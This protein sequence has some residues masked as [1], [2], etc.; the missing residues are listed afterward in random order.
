MFTML[1]WSGSP[2]GRSTQGRALPAPGHCLKPL[3]RWTNEWQPLN[4]RDFLGSGGPEWSQRFALRCRAGNTLGTRASCSP[5]SVGD[6]L[7]SRAGSPRSQVVPCKAGAG[8]ASLAWRHRNSDADRLRIA[9]YRR[10][11][12]IARRQSFEE[13]GKSAEA[14][15]CLAIHLQQYVAGLYSGQLGRRAGNHR[16][17]SHPVSVVGE[18]PA[19]YRKTRAAVLQCQPTGYRSPRLLCCL[20]GPWVP[21]AESGSRSLVDECRDFDHAG[22]VDLVRRV[23]GPVIVTVGAGEDL[24]SRHAAIN[25]TLLV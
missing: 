21:R 23:T 8:Q 3:R 16:V 17:H 6:R 14:G 24:H 19:R 9:Q 20:T 10:G 18:N 7:S 25:E 13:I 22:S 12:S 1:T 5:I 15:H 11:D 4:S 2:D